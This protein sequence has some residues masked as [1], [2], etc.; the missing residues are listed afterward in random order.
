MSDRLHDTLSTLRTDVD[1]LPLAD[2]S[3]V[4]A[5]GTQRTRRQAI[6]TSLA[7]VALVAGAV[8]IGGALTG[9]NKAET[10]LPADR[11][12]SA[13]A[14]EQTLD[15]ATDPFLRESDIPKVG[16][17]GMLRSPDSTEGLAQKKLQCMPDIS[18]LGAPQTRGQF[19]YSDGDGSF[20][21][22]VL[23][24]DST[25]AAAAAS[26]TLGQAFLNCPA[27]DASQVTVVDRQPEIVSSNGSH[28]SRLTTPTADAGISYYE[29]GVVQDANVV[30]VLQWSSMGNPEGDGATDWVWT[31]TRLQT[32]LKRA[33]GG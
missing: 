30:V 2:S 13:T 12:T 11:T 14:D 15:L 27:G 3:A 29:L 9:T 19:F 32:A 7:V 28:A 21:E 24:F 23:R 5:R 25:D 8:G 4:R 20:S 6:G 17:F 1:H 18:T 22:H 31:A 10:Q 26:V 33:L 16:S